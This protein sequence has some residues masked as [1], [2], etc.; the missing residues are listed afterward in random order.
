[1]KLPNAAH[2][3]VDRKKIIE[4]LLCATHPDGKSKAEFF[5]RFGFRVQE[6]KILAGSLLEHA[7]SHS[8]VNAVDSTFGT[9]YTIDGPLD[10]P[11]GRKPR[12]RSVWIVEK[13]STTPRLITAHPA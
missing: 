4:Y 9:R 13:G 12:V 7:R 1:M 8:V 10:A 6:W 11:D 2:A 5:G 3:R